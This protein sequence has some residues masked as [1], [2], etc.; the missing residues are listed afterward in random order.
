MTAPAVARFHILLVEDEPAG[1]RLTIETLRA[2]TPRVKVSVVPDGVEAL[3]YLR[4]EGRYGEAAR[5]DLIILDL[6]MP[7]MNGREVLA[8]VKSDPELRRIPV[9]VL[10]TSEAEE[11]VRTSYDLYANCYVAKPTDLGQFTK[12]MRRLEE[13]WFSVV[14]LPPF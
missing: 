10:T 8:A 7:R 3:A 14:R 11:D 5:P 12:T 13:F 4:R 9:V 6:N 1:A 2:S